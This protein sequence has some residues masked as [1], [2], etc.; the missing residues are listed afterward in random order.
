MSTIKNKNFSDA[1][2]TFPFFETVPEKDVQLFR[3][4]LKFQTYEK[5]ELIIQHLDHSSDFYILFEGT[6]LVNQYSSAGREV[7]YRHLV[8]GQYFGELAAIDG[9]PRSVSIMAMTR[10]T[11]GKI[12]PVIFRKLLA[13][14]PALSHAML[15]DM[16]SRVR[17]L[18]SRL[19]TTT[20]VTVPFRIDAEILKLAIAA[21]IENNQATIEPLPNH[22][23]LAALVG[24]QREA[25]TREIGRLANA[26]LVIKKT[27]A[28]IV[29]NVE[30]LIERVEM[31]SGENLL[32]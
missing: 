17:D 27:H 32:D 29:Q 11:V 24:A 5:G 21:G 2:H 31:G 19:F 18:S 10:A 6:L 14:S 23:E 3:D 13:A 1:L 15:R 20:T 9:Q 22:A 4:A 7:S 16:A 12:S 25:V 8:V 26:K 30:K 28:L